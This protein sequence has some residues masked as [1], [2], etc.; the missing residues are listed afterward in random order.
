M[1]ILKNWV[2]PLIIAVALF[3][4]IRPVL[5]Q[6]LE[7]PTNVKVGTESVDGYTQV[8]F[9]KDGQK[10]FITSGNINSRMPYAKGV[11]I[12]YVS[13]FNGAGQIFLYDI[14]SGSKI[15][16]T[17]LGVNLN[18]KVDEKGRVVWEGW[19]GKTWQIFLFDGKSTRQLTTGDTSLNPSF[20]Q[21]Y[22]AYGRR[23]I[24]GTWRTVVYSVQEDKS[25]DVTTGENTRIPEIR[26]GYIYF[27]T[28]ATEEKFPLSVSDL[29]LLN[30]VPLTA[31]SSGEP[32]T[33]SADV[34]EELSATPSGVQEISIATGS[35][36]L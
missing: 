29:F 27:G 34:I 35:G 30:L 16:L 4:L 17:L 22:V 8:Y 15:Q 6:T 21:E 20:Y 26:D 33:P 24:T 32:S 10:Q 36:S 2:L 19:D 3:F 1:K 12:S 9:E 14:A 28:A 11:Y 31:T 25:I 13:D 23:D 7:V 5:A 18:P